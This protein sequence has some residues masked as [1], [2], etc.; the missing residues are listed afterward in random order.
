M[1]LAQI[2]NYATGGTAYVPGISSPTPEAID[3]LIK[4][5]TGGVGREF[6]GLVETATTLQAG[7]EVNIQRVPLVG[8][9]IGTATDTAAVRNAFYEHLH[10]VSETKQ[11]LKGRTEHGEETASYRRDH[12]ESQLLNSA[13]TADTTVKR[14]HKEKNRLLK[15]NAPHERVKLL[16]MQVLAAMKRFNEQYSRVVP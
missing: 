15:L 10:A 2:I 12:P 5:V 9:I 6:T 8:R 16:D 14:L 1:S 11:E 7:D 4:Q 3:Y 13:H